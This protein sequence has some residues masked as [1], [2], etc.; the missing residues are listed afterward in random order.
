[1]ESVCEKCNRIRYSE[2][3]IE[4]A[5]S[6]TANYPR[7]KRV[8]RNKTLCPGFGNGI[9]SSLKI[10]MQR[11]R[12]P[13]ARVHVH[14]GGERQLQGEGGDSFRGRGRQLQGGGRQLGEGER[15]LDEGRARNVGFVFR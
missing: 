10:Q 15:C 11:P 3:E 13:F 12:D 8:G 1:M 6:C 14:R 5:L 4:A 2:R 7:L 9:F